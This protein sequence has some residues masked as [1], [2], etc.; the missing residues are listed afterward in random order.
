MANLEIIGVPPSTYTRVVRMCCEEKGV[1]YDFKIAM[2]HTPDVDAIHPFGKVPVMRHGGVELCESKAIASY[3]DRTFNGARLVPDDPQQSAEVEQ[4][5]SMINTVFDPA[6]IRDYVLGY[7]F[8]KD[9]KPDRARIDGAVAKI[10]PQLEV[11]EKAVAD[12]HLVGNGFTLAD[13]YLMPILF[14]LPKFPEGAE[15][16]KSAR[17]VSAYFDRHSKRPS[18][19]KTMPPPP[20]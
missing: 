15:L 16:M 18:F 11:L 4:W 19:Q 12:G 13:I 3:I 10:K 17:N 8:A 7:V 9:G 2:P 20:A 1:P 14:Y 6:M 5:V